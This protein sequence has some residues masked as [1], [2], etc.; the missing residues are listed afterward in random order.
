MK[1][2][3]PDGASREFAAPV[4]VQDVAQAIGAGLARAA[5]AG[6]VDGKLVDL[7][8]VI[9]NDCNLAIITD[10][11]KEGLEIIRHSTAHLMAYAVQNLYPE[12]QVTI[13]PVIEN[14]FYY[15][16]DYKRAFTPDDLEKIEKE[17][18]RLAKADIP[19]TR[20]VCARDEAVQFFL[21]KGEKYKAELIAAIP[22]N[23]VVSLYKEGEFTDLCRGPHVPS[24]GKLKAF[25]LMKVAG[26]YWRG[27]SKNPMLQRIYGTAWANKEDLNNYLTQLEEAEKRDHRKLGQ[28][29]DL[30][31]F[32]EYA[33]GAVFWHP[34]GWRL[35]QTLIE[36]MRS[37][38]EEAG[39]VEVNTPDVMDRALWETSGHWL[40]YRDNMFTTTTEDERVFALKPMNCP[41][42]VALFGYGLKSYRDLPLR[43]A[44]F[45]KVHRYE[46]SGALLGLMRVRHFT[47]DDAHIFCTTEQME[48]EC[49]R[50]VQLILDIYKDFGFENVKIKLST[51]PENRIGDDALWDILENALST[52]LNHM[53]MPYEIFPGEGAFYGPKLEFVLRDAIGRD[54]QCGTLQ[55][56]MNLPERFD[57]EYVAEDNS[58]KRPVMLHRALFGS[59]ERFIG[60]LIEHY[61]GALP[62]WLSPIPVVVMSI[63]QKQADY[64][65]N[66][67]QSLQNA[68]IQVH[69]DLRD[70]KIGYKI[71]EH[72]AKRLPYQIVVGEK[73]KENAQI[74]VRFRG[75][76]LG[77]MVLE[78]FIQRI[79]AQIKQ[80]KDLSN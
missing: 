53:Q 19:V 33:P 28:Q 64:A 27:D 10:K 65:K 17:M 59:L 52:A 48:D 4:S 77:G 34:K 20:E 74:A 7:S 54:W 62:V 56:D 63:S 13:G 39:Y 18:A 69:L 67:A 21:N 51:R 71:R 40:N 15:D 47:Q 3:L 50:V 44:E 22:E 25:K 14:G 31:H 70:E 16:F 61:A 75:K 35:F 29:L 73:E 45:G 60:I 49:K 43:M 55:V 6:K 68:G 30:F 12:A 76:D 23:E 41:G 38:Q 79:Q 37:R 57:I 1:I 24:T 11:D 46:P 36:Y 8:F 9:Q 2:T 78:D 66:V 5:L 80:K 72:S 26:A 32:E 58:R 42:A